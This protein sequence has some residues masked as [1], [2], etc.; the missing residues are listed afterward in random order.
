MYKF[1]KNL[2]KKQE[3]ENV[4]LMF[5]AI[6]AWLDEHDKDLRTRL[7]QET[8]NPVRNIRNS[9][10]RLQHIVNEIADAEHDPAI[11]PKLKTIARNSLPLFVKAMK[12]SLSK[13]LPEDI[14]EFYDA[15][16]ES[17]KGALIRGKTDQV[18]FRDGGSKNGD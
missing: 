5:S 1:F 14:E 16:V 15:V 7:R 10:S 4:T 2:L 18:G 3:A 9:I 6:P 11:H 8:D 12:A 17:V 13:D